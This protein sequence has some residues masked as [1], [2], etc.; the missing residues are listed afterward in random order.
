MEKI[1]F[2]MTSLTLGGAERVLVDIANRLVDKFDVTIFTLYSGGELEKQ[3]DKKIHVKSLYDKTYKDL[4][5]IEKIMVPLSVLFNKERIYKN[6]VDNDNYVAQIAFLEGAI[7]RIFSVKS[8]NNA[9]KIAWVH[10]DMSQV[11]GKSIKAKIKRIIDRNAYEKYDILA[12]VSVDNLDKFNKFYDDMLLPHEKVIKNYIN[13]ERILK[14]SKEQY[15]N[16]F[17]NKEVNILQVSRLVEQKAIDRLIQVHAKLIKEGVKHHIYIIGDGPLENKLKE[18]ITNNNVQKSFTL[19]GA[20][21]N[22]YPYIKNADA[23]CL[24][25]YF[26]GYPMVVEESKILNKFIAVTNTSAR[27]VL[28]D[29][30]E[31]S[32]IVENTEEG[33]EKAIKFIVKNKSKILQKNI[34]YIYE[35]NK[36]ID[37]IVKVIKEENA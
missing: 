29:Y 28:F 37:K 7:T 23:F 32:M 5:K 21:K 14:L 2:G 19:L 27:E 11:F 8:K 22:P 25:S 35:N 10:N 15:N 26:E 12:F 17:D 3:L 16:V 18:Q 1:I 13:A 24:F 33:I 30:S 36:I 20:Q 4:T 34:N 9:K 6:Y 31:N